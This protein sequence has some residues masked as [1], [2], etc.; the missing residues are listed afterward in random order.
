[1]LTLLHDKLIP[2]I[3]KTKNKDP[4]PYKTLNTIAYWFPLTSR[5][6]K[7]SYIIC[8]ICFWCFFISLLSGTVPANNSILYIYI[9]RLFLSLLNVGCWGAYISDIVIFKVWMLEVSIVNLQ[10]YYCYFG[11][12]FLS[13]WTVIDNNLRLYGTEIWCL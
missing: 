8:N 6:L 2:W 4:K 7:S 13:H 9:H 1:M 11:A 5:G 12:N 3:I 10:K